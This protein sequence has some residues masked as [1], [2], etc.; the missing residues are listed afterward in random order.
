[1]VD[2]NDILRI[3]KN[4]PTEGILAT[5]VLQFESH[6]IHTRDVLKMVITR[7]PLEMLIPFWV[8]SCART[9]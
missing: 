3:D 1:M 4:A 2:C 5:M 7:P 6:T 9:I 8:G